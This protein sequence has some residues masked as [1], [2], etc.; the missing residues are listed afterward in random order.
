MPQGAECVIAARR[1]DHAS[2]RPR[3]ALDPPLHRFQYAGG[4]R[5]DHRLFPGQH[6]GQPLLGR[7]AGR[8]CR[9]HQPGRQPAHA[10]LPVVV[11]RG[12][13]SGS[14]TGGTH[15][16]TGTDP[17]LSHAAL[18]SA[19]PWQHR[20]AGSARRCAATLAGTH[21]SA[22]RCTATAA[23]GLSPGGTGVRQ[24]AGRLRALP[25]GSLRGQAWRHPCP[26]G[27]DAVRHRADR[28]RADLRPAQ[29]PGHAAAQ[30]DQ[31]GARHRQG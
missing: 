11:H 21:A 19:P 14:G 18:G 26:A 7:C 23:G 30:P 17:A 24:G 22:A 31:A 25:A 29:Q 8:R 6:V 2:T 27:G 10:G 4:V 12:A 28:L 9:G 13:G 15:R 1:A 5:R 20:A 16:H 3:P